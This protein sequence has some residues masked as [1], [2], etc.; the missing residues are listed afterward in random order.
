M[1]GIRLAVKWQHPLRIQAL[2]QE[3]QEEDPAGLTFALESSLLLKNVDVVRAL[4]EFKADCSWVRLDKLFDPS[5]E[6]D[7]DRRGSLLL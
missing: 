6:A 2:M 7:L 5:E 4:I 1:D 3:A